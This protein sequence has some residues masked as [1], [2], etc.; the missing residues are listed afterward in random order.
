MGTT[1]RRRSKQGLAGSTAFQR[2]CTVCDDS[3]DSDDSEAHDATAIVG[4]ATSQQH[5][6]GHGGGGG[7]TE[8]GP[9]QDGHSDDH[10]GS[11]DTTDDEE[12]EDDDS[13]A[14]ATTTGQSLT[15]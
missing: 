4:A 6:H 8:H 10:V 12:D 15:W 14:R 13:D 1:V 7:D 11:N 9:T 3:D 2:R 5:Q